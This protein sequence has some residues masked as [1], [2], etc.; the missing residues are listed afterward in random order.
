MGFFDFLLFLDVEFDFYLLKFVIWCLFALSYF[1]L[2][3]KLNFY[4]LV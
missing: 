2:I 1:L 3:I 4:Q